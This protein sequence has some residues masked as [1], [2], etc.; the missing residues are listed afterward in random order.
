[1]KIPSVRRA[2]ITAA[3]LCSVAGAVWAATSSNLPGASCVAAG[4]GTLAARA[5][6]EAE[7]LTASTVT[8]VCPV[9]RP[10]GAELTTKLSATVFVVDRHASAN[11][12]CKAVSKNAGGAVVQ[13]ATVCSTGSS[14][15]Y[16][17][18]SL[19]EITDPY[20][21]SHFYVQ[22]DVPPIAS[23]AASRLQ[24]VRAVQQ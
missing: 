23:G 3:L 24:F 12:C 22:C 15:S 14:T 17:A 2:A 9:E 11:V 20:T 19:A 4:S 21:F 1:M 16:Q 6:G 10:M 18:L 5:D 8:A 7:N 13:S